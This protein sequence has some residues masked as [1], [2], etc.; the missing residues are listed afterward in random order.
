MQWLVCFLLR[1]A[2]KDSVSRAAQVFVVAAVGITRAIVSMT[3]STSSAATLIDKVKTH[4]KHLSQDFTLTSVNLEL[5]MV[6]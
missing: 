5:I 3:V 4:T 1:F 6:I 2:L